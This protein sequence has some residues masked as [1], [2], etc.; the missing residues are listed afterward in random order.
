MNMA[1]SLLDLRSGQHGAEGSGLHNAYQNMAPGAT[2]RREKKHGCSDQTDLLCHLTAQFMSKWLLNHSEPVS[3]TVNE[4]SCVSRRDMQ[5]HIPTM[6]QCLSH[7]RYPRNVCVLLAFVLW[8]LPNP[9][10]W[11]NKPHSCEIR[12]KQL[13]AVPAELRT[14]KVSS[15]RYITELWRGCRV[16]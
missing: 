5:C 9:S 6:W 16:F 2:Q 10:S 14:E 4:E 11:G 13:S 8:T 15:P 12:Y 3:T 1:L 7:S